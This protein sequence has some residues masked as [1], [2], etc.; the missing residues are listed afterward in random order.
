[1]LLRMVESG[2][3]QPNR[4]PVHEPERKHLNFF[5]SET[6]TTEICTACSACVVA[7]PHHVIE[8]QDFRPAMQ[9]S[10]LGIDNCQHGEKN[11]SLCAMAC[12]RLDPDFDAIEQVLYG[13]RRKHPS[14][15][16]AVTRKM[17]LG[18]TTSPEITA[19]SQ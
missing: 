5:F 19:R 12:L 13:R 1:M 9:D 16:W 17:M 4:V 10:L 8:M 14:E 18:R 2:T 6:V 7:C 3:P 15:P 11:C